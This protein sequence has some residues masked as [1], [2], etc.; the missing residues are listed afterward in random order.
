MRLWLDNRENAQR[1]EELHVI[2][3]DFWVLLNSSF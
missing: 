2:D 3:A 1:L